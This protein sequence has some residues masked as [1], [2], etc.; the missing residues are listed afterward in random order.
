MAAIGSVFSFSYKEIMGM[1]IRDLFFL[2]RA[3]K[4]EI[5]RRRLEMIQTFRIANCV[6]TAYSM[7]IKAIEMEIRKIDLG[8]KIVIDSGWD[9]LKTMG[10]GHV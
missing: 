5:L 7:E 4:R 2:V 6:D 1:D 9:D 3:A 10:E 8:K